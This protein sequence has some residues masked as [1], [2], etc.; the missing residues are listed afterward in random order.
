V[1]VSP[2]NHFHT[3]YLRSAA[4]S[5]VLMRIGAGRA[6]IF[7]NG[8]FS[9]L[10]GMAELSNWNGRMDRRETPRRVRR[11]NAPTGAPRASAVNCL[12]GRVLERSA[13][14]TRR[15]NG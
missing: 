14:S 12:Y 7:H 13:P 3:L 6:E 10:A 2:T 1:D 8:V 11:G 5:D 9:E 4:I 15:T